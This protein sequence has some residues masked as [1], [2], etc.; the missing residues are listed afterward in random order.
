[1]H[2]S[3]RSFLTPPRFPENDEKMQRAALLHMALLVSAGFVSL[4]LVAIAVGGNV[5]LR[6]LLIV[7]LL[8][9][10]LI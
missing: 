8:L 5:P 9:A 10:L 7:A 6:T 4:A 1:M 2:T 3:L